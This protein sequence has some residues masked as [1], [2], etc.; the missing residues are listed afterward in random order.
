MDDVEKRVLK[1]TSSILTDITRGKKRIPEI[2][3]E[4]DN[5]M[6]AIVSLQR[7]YGEL[8]LRLKDKGYDGIVDLY[9]DILNKLENLARIFKKL[10]PFLIL[11]SLSTGNSLREE[12]SDVDMEFNSKQLME[13]LNN[14]ID[15]SL[16]PE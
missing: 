3:A 1:V 13:K 12:S 2:V 16:P 15:V 4:N 9:E 8:N 11:F 7:K 6:T 5:Y 10:V 14:F